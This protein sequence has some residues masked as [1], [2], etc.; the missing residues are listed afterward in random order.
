MR[1]FDFR[2]T[3]Q[4]GGRLSRRA[5]PWIMLSTGAL[6]LLLAIRLAA[7]SR[8]FDKSKIFNRR[9]AKGLAA[10]GPV[11]AGNDFYEIFIEDTTVGAGIGLYSIRTDSLHPITLSPPFNG[12]R[13]DILAGGSI[14][15]AGTSYL[16]V[17]SYNSNRDYVQTEF[18]AS[19]PGFT[20]VWLDTTFISEEFDIPPPGIVEPIGATG[21]RVTYS[22]PGLARLDTNEVIIDN[23]EITQL[24]N[25][26][27]RNFD[28]SW[29]EV[30][31]VVKNLGAAE[32]RVGIRY[33]WDLKV[34]GD[35]GPILMLKPS[36]SLGRNEKSVSDFNFEFFVAE[37][38]DNLNE[39]T[40]PAYN[41]YGSVLTPA[42]LVPEPRRPERLKQVSWPLAFLKAFTYETTPT[43]NV[44]DEPN[45]AIPLTGGDNAILYYWGD[46]W[47]SAMLVPRDDSIQ[48]TQA[49]IATRPGERPGFLDFDPPSCVLDVIN[50]GPPK[51][52]EF[53]VQDVESGLR[54]IRTVQ[55]FNVSVKVPR[56]AVGTTDPVRV[57]YTVVNPAQPFG[58]TLKT[59]DVSGNLISC[60]PIFLTLMP[61]L[62]IF[63]YRVE[64]IYSDRYFYV[65]NQGIERITVG[66][67]GHAFTLSAIDQAD[68][69]RNVFRMPL[70]GEMSIDIFRYL[71]EDAN[72]MTIAFDGPLG[73]R[74]DLIVSDMM[75]KASVDLVLNLTAV[76][77]KF[78][79]QQNM[80]NPFRGSTTIGFEV[81]DLLD[82]KQKVELKIYNLLG[83]LVRTLSEAELPAGKHLV[84]WDGRDETGRQVAAGIY[85]YNLSANGTT[86]TKKMTLL[87]MRRTP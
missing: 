62:R 63:E 42:V 4:S 5:M 53:V 10:A 78:V 16:T 68:G 20:T 7:D 83:Q 32:A 59:M 66:L 60:D 69:S 36:G 41:V 55:D 1:P 40:P 64:P 11:I 28:D 37:A 56:F 23:L 17:R 46:S 14:D 38:N 57:V 39:I 31:T 84:S 48:V 13:Q 21:F 33:L 15:K 61:D 73:S 49:L 45:P 52:I 67:N 58:F 22:I 34:A 51:S 87:R 70:N 3:R 18:A 29:V 81:P 77:E 12:A 43:L 79:L 24:V 26:H 9:L 44:V 72:T 80:P 85:V 2:K 82:D 35:D 27:G 19:E 76:P 71:K 30:T 50:P 75:M 8:L 86:M 74:A 25:V 54:F 6:L 65:K 47:E